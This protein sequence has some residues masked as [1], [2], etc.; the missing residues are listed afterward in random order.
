MEVRKTHERAPRCPGLGLRLTLRPVF[1]DSLFHL[2]DAPAVIILSEF[3]LL[4]ILFGESSV[5]RKENA[6]HFV[7]IL[8]GEI[9]FDRG[10]IS[11]FDDPGDGH[12]WFANLDGTIFCSYMPLVIVGI[13]NS[14]S[15]QEALD[16]PIFCAS[17]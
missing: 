12:I 16:C 2:G 7:E 6:A 14:C 10:M 8:E 15:S 13:I 5:G 11:L 1:P 9:K 17:G 4:G 3:R